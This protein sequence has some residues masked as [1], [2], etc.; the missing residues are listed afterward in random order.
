MFEVMISSVYIFSQNFVWMCE[1]AVAGHHYPGD[2]RRSDF[3]ELVLRDSFI[4][5][6]ESAIV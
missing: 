6:L 1:P 5:I 4:V 2:L 3:R